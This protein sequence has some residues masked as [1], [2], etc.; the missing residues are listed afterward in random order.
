MDMKFSETKSWYCEVASV[1][2]NDNILYFVDSVFSLSSVYLPQSKNL[3]KS[4]RKPQNACFP[5]SEPEH[6]AKEGKKEND[7]ENHEE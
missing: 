6:L 7:T 1:A 4:P 3:P 5:C 2:E